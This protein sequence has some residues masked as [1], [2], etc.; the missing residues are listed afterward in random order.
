MWGAATGTSAI[1]RLRAFPSSSVA[2][3]CSTA[4]DGAGVRRTVLG[5][6]LE[7]RLGHILGDGTVIAGDE[8]RCDLGPTGPRGA[9]EFRSVTGVNEVVRTFMTLA[10][11]RGSKW[12][13]PP[14][15]SDPEDDVVSSHRVSSI[16]YLF[17]GVCEAEA[18]A[19]LVCRLTTTYE[20]RTC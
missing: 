4:A 15:A 17:T 20:I 6:A 12:L 7:D 8:L 9:A 2:W 14:A 3:A 16:V 1:A 18:I 13:P 19:A 11:V 5:P 10:P